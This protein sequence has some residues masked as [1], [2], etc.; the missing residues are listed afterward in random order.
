MYFLDPG[1][2]ELNCIDGKQ[3]VGRAAYIENV[4]HPNTS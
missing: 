2:K 4:S 1:M 3:L